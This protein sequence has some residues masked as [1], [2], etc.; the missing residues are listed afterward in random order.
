[1]N[2]LFRYM[3]FIGPLFKAEEI[4][5]TYHNGLWFSRKKNEN[6]NYLRTFKMPYDQLNDASNYNQILNLVKIQL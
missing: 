4:F 6:F 3:Y 1:M 5:M 2:E